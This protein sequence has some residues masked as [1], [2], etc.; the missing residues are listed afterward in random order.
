MSSSRPTPGERKGAALVLRR[1]GG[2]RIVFAVKR[3][4]GVALGALAACET[5]PPELPPLGPPVVCDLGATRD[6]MN[7]VPLYADE[8]RA[9]CEAACAGGEPPACLARAIMREYE[10]PPRYV[11]AV[12][13]YSLLCS[14]GYLPACFPLARAVASGRGALVDRRRAAALLEETCAAG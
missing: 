6:R 12:E 11:E 4:L 8:E 13:S 2:A 1:R 10:D 3:L 5:P 7:D 9:A 14:A